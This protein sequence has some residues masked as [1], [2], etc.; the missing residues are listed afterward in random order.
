[1]NSVDI[2]NQFRSNFSFHHDYERRNWRPLAWF[3][4][5]VCLGNSYFIWKAKQAH[6]STYLRSKFNRKLINALLMKGTEH[7]AEKRPKK[8]RCVWGAKHLTDCHEGVSDHKTERQRRQI[9]RNNAKR[10][11][12][13]VVSGNLLRRPLVQRAK[14]TVWGC[15]SCK[16]NLCV[17]KGC[18]IKYHKDLHSK[19]LWNTM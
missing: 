19:L 2:A 5:D 14:T 8:Q 6:Q 3:L 13:G 7:K 17:K 15:N 11:P 4:L 1:M 12:L 18:F 10:L 16:V 9:A